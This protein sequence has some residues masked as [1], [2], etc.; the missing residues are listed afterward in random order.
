MMNH[1]KFLFNKWQYSVIFLF[2]LFLNFELYASDDGKARLISYPAPEGAAQNSDFSVSVRLAGQKW[3]DLPE[4]LI[5]VDEVRGT[6]HAIESA[7]MSYFDF[8]GEVEVS[9]TYNKGDV[10][11]ARIRPLSY[12]INPEIKGKTI[13]FKLTKARNLSVEVNGDIFH[14]LHLFANPVDEFIPEK[15]DTNLIYF[16]PGI[17]RITNG[18]LKIT[19]GKTVYLAGGAILMGQVLIEGVENVKLIGRG[20]I[21][22][23][24]K[25]GVRIANSKNVEVEGIFCTQCATGGSDHVVIRN[26]KSIS[27]YGWGDG[28]NVF[29]SNNVLFDGVFCRNSDDCTTVYGTRGGFTGGCRNITMQNSTLW[30]DVAHPILIGTHGNTPNPEVLEDLT[31]INIDILDHKEPQVDYQGCMSLNAGDSN[32]IR[33]VRFENIRIEDFRQGQLVNLRVFFNSKYCTSP[34]RGIENILFKDVTY[35]GKNAELSIIAG[36]DDQRKVKNVVFEN[37][38]INGAK[39]TDNMKGKPGWFKTSDMARFFVGEH[40]EGITFK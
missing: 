21:D 2:A 38:V 28:M 5:K 17:H 1:S 18:K 14:N 20:M 9:V 32:L 33:N 29:S 16:G 37:L 3:Q 13:T 39:I 23:T 8:S 12:G 15:K 10:N 40:V 26:V 27:Y 19:S 22:H 7:S 4:Y 24:V 31:Y 35:N 36:Y 11:S 34:G 6:N 25:M 30:A